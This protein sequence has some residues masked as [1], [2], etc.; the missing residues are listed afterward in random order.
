[1]LNVTV[2]VLGFLQDFGVCGSFYYHFERKEK[3]ISGIP[4]DGAKQFGA[5]SGLIFVESG[6]GPN[7]SQR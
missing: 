1:M 6:L 2:C 4:P 3:Y 5:R 7:C